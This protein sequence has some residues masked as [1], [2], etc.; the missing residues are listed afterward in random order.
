MYAGSNRPRSI[1]RHNCLEICKSYLEWLIV[2]TYAMQRNKWK[3]L[4]LHQQQPM[5]GPL[6]KHAPTHLYFNIQQVN[7]WTPL[8]SNCYLLQLSV[9]Q[10]KHMHTATSLLL[11]ELLAESAHSGHIVSCTEFYHHQSST[12]YHNSFQ[13]AKTAEAK[14]P[15]IFYS[16]SLL[17]KY[18][19][20][21]SPW[22]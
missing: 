18:R 3:S 6:D 10:I 9:I 15:F 12:I 22:N 17:D 21:L 2:L 20:L 19:V 4:L 13:L 11:H 16:I 7:Q 1:S 14:W 8:K 5:Q